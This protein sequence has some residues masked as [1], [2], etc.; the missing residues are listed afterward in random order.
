[1][2]SRVFVASV[3]YTGF[4]GL[5]YGAKPTDITVDGEVMEVAGGVGG[6]DMY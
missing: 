4:A 2:C 6:A 5:K 3:D 1:M